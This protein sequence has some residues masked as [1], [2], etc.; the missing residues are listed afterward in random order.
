MANIDELKKNLLLERSNYIPMAELGVHPDIKAKFLG[1]KIITLQDDIDFWYKAGYDYIKLQPKADFNPA[2]IG[3]SNETSFKEDGTIQFNWAT[4]GKGVISSFEDFEKYIFP[5]KND[6]DYSNFE[7]VKKY[8]PDG[9]GV[10]GQ[11]GDIFTMTWELMGFENFSFALF[12]N[13]ELIKV[14]NEKIGNLI[15]SMFEY[16][17]QSDKVDIIWF[18]D[19]IAYTNG[20]LMSPEVLDEYFFPWL[21]KIGDLAK[22]YSKPLIYHTDGVLFD[23]FDKIIECGVN[24]I[25]PIEPK[26]MNLAE[27]KSKFGKKLA[28]IGHVD[29]D[30]LARASKDEVIKVIEKNIE[31][32][33]EHTGYCVGSGNSIPAY[34]NYDNYLAMLDFMKS[35]R[36]E[37]QL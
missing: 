13:P 31:I 35:L 5:S 4:E 21:R 12:E 23:V 9:M 32:A 11:Y 36:A 33:W 22:R 26:A 25:H 29:V 2:K 15:L 6:F 8:L 14:V 17:A 16:F 37:S 3:L 10:I 28:L 18:S 30:L 27:V 24:A 7:N 34:V 19:D 20:L 1:R